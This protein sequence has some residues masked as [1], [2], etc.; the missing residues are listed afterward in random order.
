MVTN[1]SVIMFKAILHAKYISYKCSNCL[2][3][4][5]GSVIS[6]KWNVAKFGKSY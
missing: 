3:C 2:K 5:V 1:I 4:Y 6:D